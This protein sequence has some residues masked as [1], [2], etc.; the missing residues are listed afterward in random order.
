MGV[1]TNWASGRELD[2]SS[3]PVEHVEKRHR[4]VGVFLVIFSLLWG[5]FPTL[6][7]IASILNGSF[8][9]AML[10][11]LVF[12]IVGTGLFLFGL[13]LM[14]TR[15][16][17]RFDRDRIELDER[18]IFGHK[19]WTEPL[20]RYAGVRSRSE[21]HSGGKNQSS[22][23][24]YICELHH[25]DPKKKVRLYASRVEAGLRKRL[26]R[27][28]RQL[29]LPAL[30]GDDSNLTVRSVEDLDKSVRDLVR[31]GKL[32]VQFDPTQP[33]PAG[34][35]LQVE[36][37]RLQIELPRTRFPLVAGLIGF[38]VPGVFIWIGFGVKEVPLFFGLIGVLV[39][40]GFL[41]V[42]AWNAIAVTVVQVDPDTIRW[43][44]RVPWGETAGRTIESGHVE[45]IRAGRIVEN[46][47]RMGVL[48]VTDER[49]HVLGSGLP[50]E[51][52]DWLCHCLLAVISRG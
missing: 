13:K 36:G 42:L 21:Y 35:G 33:P 9:P 27:Y 48:L 20:D 2:L 45:S 41:F 30:E 22:Y 34:I 16:V 7:L 28:C 12:S 6:F 52:L 49:T 39:A 10:F 4:G 50:R 5:G 51:S 40:C 47:A 31:E 37:N 44:Q 25:E 24:L 19:N 1:S 17:I 46:Q 29:G 38:L 26:E 14:T 8:E 18:S 15:R 32:A 11:V 23:T 43:F 3:L